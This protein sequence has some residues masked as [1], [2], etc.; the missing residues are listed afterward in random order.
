M[1]FSKPFLLLDSEFTFLKQKVS[2]FSKIHGNI[3]I[4]YLVTDND[5]AFSYVDDITKEIMDIEDIFKIVTIRKD[6]KNTT[7]IEIDNTG[8]LKRVDVQSFIEGIRS[9]LNRNGVA[10]VLIPVPYQCPL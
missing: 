5:E 4:L 1:Q 10:L 9:Y 8:S 3:Q 6:G 7:S 2:I